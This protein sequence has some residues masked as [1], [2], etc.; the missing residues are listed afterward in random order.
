MPELYSNT[1]EIEAT[2]TATETGYNWST[3]V[4]FNTA[5]DLNIYK[6]RSVI[7]SN[8][9]AFTLLYRL[10]GAAKDQHTLLAGEQI[11]LD[12]ISPGLWVD[13]NDGNVAF[14]AV[15]LG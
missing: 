14:R 6:V 10:S 13:A 5:T 11:K 1:F 7:L 9:G 12:V 2:A 8:D 15:G 4:A 3:G